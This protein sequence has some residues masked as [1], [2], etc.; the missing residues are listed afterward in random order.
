MLNKPKHIL[1][2]QA[3]LWTEYMPTTYQVEYMAYP[4]AIALAEV[5]WTQPDKRQF[6]DFHRRLQAHYLLLQR[7]AVNYYRP[8]TFLAV[9]ASN[10]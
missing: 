4:R 2:V 9:Y 8:S 1:G 6:D 5:A 10:T 3:N 7:Q